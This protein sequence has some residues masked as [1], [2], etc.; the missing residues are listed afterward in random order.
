MFDGDPR[1]VEEIVESIYVSEH[2]D[3]KSTC[4]EDVYEAKVDAVSAE[5]LSEICGTVLGAASG[6]FYQYDRFGARIAVL[7]E[8]RDNKSLLVHEYLHLMLE[9]QG[10][11]LESGDP[12]HLDVVWES[13]GQKHGEHAA[14]KE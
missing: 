9:C 10:G 13:V 1:S 6:C 7:G 14:Y 3:M 12:Y 5:R 8:L 4:L 11:T 2:G